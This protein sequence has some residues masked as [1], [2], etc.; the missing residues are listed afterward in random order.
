MDKINLSFKDFGEFDLVVVGGGC[1][2]VFAAVKAASR[3]R[4]QP[5]VGRSS[6]RTGEYA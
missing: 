2:G 1:A 3:S 5:C 6:A 4:P